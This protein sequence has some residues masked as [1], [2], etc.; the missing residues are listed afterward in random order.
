[1][2]EL[3]EIP[4]AAT[5][6]QW[7]RYMAQV[8]EVRGW[9]QADELERFLLFSE[10]VGEFAKALRRKRKLFMQVSPNSEPDPEAAQAREAV[11]S[12][13]AD[14]FSYLLDLA[15]SQGVD[16]EEAFRQK[17]IENRGR[18]WASE[19]SATEGSSEG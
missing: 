7:Q 1:M 11:A 13:L 8:C 9:A 12:E 17:E 16:L 3:P 6:S 2:R 15:E 4:T 10:E 18:A 14:L 19:C 5:L